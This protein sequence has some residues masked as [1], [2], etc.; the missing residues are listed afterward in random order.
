M[1]GKRE[2]MGSGKGWTNETHGGGGRA[3]GPMMIMDRL[4]GSALAEGGR[5]RRRVS[6]SARLHVIT[7]IVV[8]V[9]VV[10]F[11]LNV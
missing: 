3:V 10:R 8:G 9:I 1:A 11:S 5:R 4:T 2:G 6:L 7:I